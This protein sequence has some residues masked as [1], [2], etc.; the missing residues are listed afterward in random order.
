MKKC[1]CNEIFWA[2]MGTPICNECVSAEIWKA[3]RKK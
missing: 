3:E 2:P 1:K